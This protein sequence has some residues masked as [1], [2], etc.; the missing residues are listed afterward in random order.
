MQTQTLTPE[1]Y[2]LRFGQYKNMRAVDV[3][4]IY[5][6]DRYGNNYPKGLMYLQFLCKTD[7][8]RQIDILQKI[9]NNAVNDISDDK[10]RDRIHSLMN[11]D[12]KTTKDKKPKEKTTSNIVNFD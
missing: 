7:W 10:E 6:I 1:N 12:K 4:K 8:F 2:V 5:V 9:I 11:K 3:A